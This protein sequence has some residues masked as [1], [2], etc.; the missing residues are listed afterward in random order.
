VINRLTAES[1]E[2]AENRKN[3]MRIPPAFLCEL[4]GEI[5]R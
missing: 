3:S 1:V 5:L 4:R 2:I